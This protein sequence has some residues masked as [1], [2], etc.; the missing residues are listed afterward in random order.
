MGWPDQ[1]DAKDFKDTLLDLH[2]NLGKLEKQLGHLICELLQVKHNEYERYFEGGYYIASMNHMHASSEF[3]ERERQAII[4]DQH[5]NGKKSA[6]SH[7]DGAPFVT[8]LIADQ[9]GLEVFA[10]GWNK[11]VEVPVVPG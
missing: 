11:W 5:K 4:E 8:L 9:P 3:S 10:N 2:Q 7:V 1:L 6:G